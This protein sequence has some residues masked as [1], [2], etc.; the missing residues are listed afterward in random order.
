MIRPLLINNIGALLILASCSSPVPNGQNAEL[1]PTEF[2]IDRS[3]PEA[4]LRSIIGAIKADRLASLKDLCEPNGQCDVACHTMCNIATDDMGHIDKFKRWFAQAEQTAPVT[5][6][7]DSAFLHLKLDPNGN[8]R[9][10]DLGL[11]KQNEE[12]YLARFKWQ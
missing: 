9:L 5:F 10:V 11:I 1:E 2:S 7:G 12:W 6:A 3:T 8:S 4:V